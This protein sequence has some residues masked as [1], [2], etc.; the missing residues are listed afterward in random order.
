MEK[1]KTFKSPTANE[2]YA[3]ATSLNGK[4]QRWFKSKESFKRF[5]E[6]VNKEEYR[7]VKNKDYL[8]TGQ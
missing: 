3:F 4:T 6:S 5:F 1:V 8:L 2:M 7:I